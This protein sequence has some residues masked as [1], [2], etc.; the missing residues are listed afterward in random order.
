MQLAPDTTHVIVGLG[1]TGV[2]CARWLRRQ[3]VKFAAVD[4]R[5]SP[6]GI[7]VFRQEFADVQ[8]ECGELREETLLQAQVLVMSPGVDPRVLP[9]RRAVARGARL[10]GD[11]DLFARAVKAPLVAITGS[12]AK[13]TVTTL[14]GEMAKTAGVNVAVCGNIGTPVLDMLDGGHHDLYVLELS[15]F[16]LETTHNLGAKVATV[17][18]ISPDH[19]DR[20]DSM[21]AYHAAKHRIF[22]GCQQVV[23]NRDDPLSRPL[24]PTSIKASSFGLAADDSNEYA[25]LER[26]GRRWLAFNREPLLAVDELKIAG[27]HNVANALASLAL[28]RAAGLEFAP[29]LQALR[30]FAGLPHRCQWVATINGVGWYND[31]KGTNVGASVAA[32]V[33]L[34]S[35]GRIVLLAGGVGKGAEFTALAPV[36]RKYG[37]R[38]IVFGEDA[39]K[40][41]SALDGV[42]PVARVD[43]FEAAVARAHAEAVAGEL[44]LLSPACASFDMFDNY[45]HRGRVFTQLVRALA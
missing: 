36:M 40:I 23:I 13:S 17:L 19:L 24:L 15:S 4:T 3:G 34:G 32:I 25:V 37:S 31:S 21:Q 45:E 35:S 9:V 10:T 30:N 27:Q 6:P 39:A 8:L 2:S 33:G 7:D 18:N 38:A 41:A 14:V 22:Q 12:N 43:S 42:V 1:K 29:M 28:G 44:V 16:Q 26:G 5:V 20:Y 11:V